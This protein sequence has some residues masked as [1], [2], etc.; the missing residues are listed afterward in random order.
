MAERWARTKEAGHETR[1]EDIDKRG[2]TPGTLQGPGFAD[3]EQFAQDAAQVVR[4]GGDRVAFLDVDQ[5]AEPA[6]AHA[7]AV[8]SVTAGARLS[9]QRSNPA[10]ASSPFSFS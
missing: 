6:A 7:A 1:D 2:K 9:I 5:P 10:S 3:S 8:A 4:R